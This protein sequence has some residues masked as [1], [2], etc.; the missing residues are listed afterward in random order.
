[1]QIRDGVLY[2]ARIAI[3]ARVPVGRY[4]AETFLIQDGHV[5]AGAVTDV[6]IAKG[7]F[8]RFVATAAR[9]WSI[10]YGLVAVALSVGIGWAAGVPFR[11]RG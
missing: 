1:M 10:A 3:P 4:S 8:E 5:V 6:R 11:R 2:R 9:R 7:G